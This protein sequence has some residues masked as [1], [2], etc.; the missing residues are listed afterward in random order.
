MLKLAFIFPGQ[1]AQYVG[2]G[3]ELAAQYPV[4]RRVFE[5][6]DDL[7]GYRLS[8]TCFESLKEELD[9]TE[10]TQPAVL[11]TS[12]AAFAVLQ[13]EGVQPDL[14]AGLSLG[15][16]AALVASGMLDFAET[17]LLVVTRARLMQEAVPVGAGLMAAVLGVDDTIIESA[18]REAASRGRV[19]IANYNCPG[20]VVIS[21]ETE[22]VQQ[23]G[24]ILKTKGAK[25]LPLCVSVPS[26]SWLM[27][28]AADRLRQELERLNLGT[29]IFPVVS[30]VTASEVDREAVADLLYRQLFSPVLWHQ[31]LV[32]MANRADGFIEVGPGKVLSTF[33]K[34]I[35]SARL[36]GNVED[37][38]S[39]AKTL[40]KLKDAET[41]C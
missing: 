35:P 36:L 10:V 16:Y 9:N 13:A 1:G 31:S 5:Q 18:C 39:L 19:G 14:A 20:Q 38:G 34:K 30:N 28:P 23:A 3:K 8:K 33:V 15:E 40:L 29:P 37:A 25:V 17:L 4:A 11:T 7:L 32:Y 22:A 6:A 24:T 2:M 27:Q 41:G 21:G 12:I 26:H